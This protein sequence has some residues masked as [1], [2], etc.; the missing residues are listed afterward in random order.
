MDHNGYSCERFG[1]DLTRA[2]AIVAAPV[3]PRI[4]ERAFETF[5]RDFRTGTVLW[6][7]TDR[8]GDPLSFRLFPPS[9]VNTL[10]RAIDA[11]LLSENH[12]LAALAASW[13]QLYGGKTLHSY[14]FDSDFGLTKTW[15][16]FGSRRPQAEI[17]TAPSVPQ[18]ITRRVEEFRERGLHDISFA[19][20][21]WRYNTVVLD[22]DVPGP[23][24]HDSLTALVATT[25][26]APV[27]E[28]LAETV[29]KHI[30]RDH[31]VALSVDPADGRALDCGFSVMDVPAAGLPPL[32]ARLEAFFADVP[33]RAQ[34]EFNVLGW[35]F[36]QRGPYV[37]TERQYRGDIRSLLTRW[38]EH[39][40]DQSAEMW[41]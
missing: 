11:G 19:A 25:G 8:S 17:L 4:A 1:T 37:K 33:T 28:E 32:P 6:R 29:I 20:I 30:S 27:P 12:P 7:C 9:R 24:S 14:A 41:T 35:S 16:Y 10:T 40:G 23:L 39:T 36:G 18:P 22:F 34:N 21:D 2:A 31:C 13:S 38:E 26:A 3:D 5:R 15:I